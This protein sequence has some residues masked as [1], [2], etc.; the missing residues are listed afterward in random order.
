MP[1]ACPIFRFSGK[2]LA[3]FSL[4]RIILSVWRET[5]ALLGQFL[6]NIRVRLL[7]NEP[8]FLFFLWI[9]PEKNQL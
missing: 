3:T 2:W 7:A 4:S 6:D 1:F 8:H 5:V 9:F